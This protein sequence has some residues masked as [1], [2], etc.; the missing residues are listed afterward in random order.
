MISPWQSQVNAGMW[1]LTYDFSKLYT[2]NEPVKEPSAWRE[3]SLK[4]YTAI[5]QLTIL[6]N[7][8][9]YRKLG[10]STCTLSISK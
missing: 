7:Y 4:K 9:N 1:R 6:M 8:K 3:F 5:I 2:S 10:S